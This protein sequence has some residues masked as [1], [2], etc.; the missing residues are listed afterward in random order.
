[1]SLGAETI[2]GE[3]V[4]M[5]VGVETM[6]LLP[7]AETMVLGAETIPGGAETIPG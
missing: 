7:V 5:V 3:A 1:M 6:A 2:H 4:I